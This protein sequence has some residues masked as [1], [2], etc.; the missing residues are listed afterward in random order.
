MSS[1]CFLLESALPCD[2]DTR[3]LQ[4]QTVS[5]SLE[6]YASHASCLSFWE[7]MKGKS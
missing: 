7:E 2:P 6:L 3:Q 5:F 1:T 4:V